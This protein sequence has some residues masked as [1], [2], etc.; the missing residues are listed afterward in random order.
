MTRFDEHFL[1]LLIVNDWH[2]NL[3]EDIWHVAT[4]RGKKTFFIPF[5]QILNF[6]PRCAA[7]QQSTCLVIQPIYRFSSLSNCFGIF[8][9]LNSR[10]YG[11]VLFLT[12]LSST[13]ITCFFKGYLTIFSSSPSGDC[14][15][16][17]YKHLVEGLRH[18]NGNNVRLSGD[19]RV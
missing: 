7:R 12:S 18:T 19:I 2:C 11:Q 8:F 4:W 14:T 6:T 16:L 5:Q 13:K 15:H 10:S 9:P 1:A 17:T 3:M